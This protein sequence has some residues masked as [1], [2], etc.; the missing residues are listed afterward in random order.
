MRIEGMSYDAGMLGTSN[1]RNS[2]DN[3]LTMV[4]HGGWVDSRGGGQ[5]VQAGFAACGPTSPT[6]G[7]RWE[8]A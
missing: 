3:D 8:T 7:D 4:L 1:G 6:L 2:F 5:R